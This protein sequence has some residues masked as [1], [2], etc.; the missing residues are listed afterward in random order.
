M[1]RNRG[2]HAS[3]SFREVFSGLIYD[4]N[5]KKTFVADVAVFF[6]PTCGRW[7]LVMNQ[8]VSPFRTGSIVFFHKIRHFPT[9]S[10][11]LTFVLR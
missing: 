7:T 9:T 1:T 4:T 5:S 2:I 11:Q 8:S 3:T 6:V 10:L